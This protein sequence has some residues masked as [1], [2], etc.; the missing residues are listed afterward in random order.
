MYNIAILKILKGYVGKPQRNKGENKRAVLFEPEGKD[1]RTVLS[2][3][4][5]RETIPRRQ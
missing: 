1:K 5:L 2:R 3:G 4:K